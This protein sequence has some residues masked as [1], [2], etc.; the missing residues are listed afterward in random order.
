MLYDVFIYITKVT[1]LSVDLIPE[2]SELRQHWYHSKCNKLP[3]SLDTFNNKFYYI[4]YRLHIVLCCY[5]FI[6][7]RLRLCVNVFPNM[8]FTHT[9][10]GPSRVCSTFQ[11]DAYE[12]FWYT[13]NTAFMIFTTH[14]GTMKVICKTKLTITTTSSCRTLGPALKTFSHFSLQDI[15]KG[16]KD[17]FY[18][19]ADIT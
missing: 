18:C 1:V 16:P 10:L 2:V 9:M 7:Y 6:I 4:F 3:V 17:P 15:K 8:Q 19:L 14:C 12:S 5:V 13:T 11:P